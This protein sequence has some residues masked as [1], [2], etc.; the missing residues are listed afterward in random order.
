MKPKYTTL[1]QQDSNHSAIKR[2]GLLLSS[3]S[4]IS[5]KNVSTFLVT[6]NTFTHYTNPILSLAGNFELYAQYSPME[7]F[8]KLMNEWC[9]LIC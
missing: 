5:L 2:T 3:V 4:K 1:L 6:P 8:D 7:C 9:P